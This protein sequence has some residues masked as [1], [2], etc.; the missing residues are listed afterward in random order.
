MADPVR[1]KLLVIGDGTVGKTCLLIVYT[2]GTFPLKYIPTVFENHIKDVT[3][4]ET[5]TTVELVLWD[6]AG[7][8]EVGRY[9]LRSLYY[10]NSDVVVICYAIDSPDSLENV[11]ENWIQEVRHFCPKIPVLLVGT[12]SDLRNDPQTIA[13][14]AKM[15]QRPVTFEEGQKMSQ[16]INA[17]GY[18]ETSAKSNEGIPI[19][20]EE[21]ARA[22]ASSTGGGAKKGGTQSAGSGGGTGIQRDGN[23][24][25]GSKK[26]SKCELL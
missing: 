9:R 17:I 3:I 19:V 7:Q 2:Q 13:S 18:Y 14:L 1:K 4:P 26:K 20:F 11:A 23:W 10:P 8:E 16:Q 22:A 6:T 24:V 25:G 5:N 21:A 15:G 12:K